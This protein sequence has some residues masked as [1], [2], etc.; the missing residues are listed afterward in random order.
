MGRERK[1]EQTG[2]EDLLESRLTELLSKVGHCA[3]E[4]LQ[5]ELHSL[6]SLIDQY[7]RDNELLESLASPIITSDQRAEL[8]Q[9]LQEQRLRVAANRAEA[10]RL[11]AQSQRVLEHSAVL[12][13][14][15]ERRVY[16]RTHRG[17]SYAPELCGLCRGIGGDANDPCPACKGRRT[18][19]AHQPPVKCPHCTG[20]GK[21]TDHDRI[22]FALGVCLVCRGRGWALVIEE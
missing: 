20:T 16:E 22:Q 13:A 8:R 3:V 10:E 4:E 18:V 6:H 17:T 5:A 11:H 2:F 1:T 21:P 12:L 14:K 7:K 19:L 9:Q 15:I